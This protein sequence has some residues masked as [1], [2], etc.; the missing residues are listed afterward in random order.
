MQKPN[1]LIIGLAR[2]GTTS[3]Y[4]YL[5]QHPDIFLPSIKE[6]KFFSGRNIQYPHKGKGDDIVDNSRILNVQEYYSL[7]N[8]SNGEKAIGEASSDYFYHIRNC[9]KD[10]LTELG[11]ETK[12]ILCLRD[13]YERSF[14]AYNNLIRDSRETLSFSKGLLQEDYRKE[15]NY[16]WMWYYREGSIYHDKLK[17]ILENFHNVHL[18]FFED[19]KNNVDDTLKNICKFLCVDQNFSFD[20]ATKYSRSGKPK[21]KI[22]KI[23]TKR[24]G[25]IFKARKAIMQI[26]P[27]S[28][29]ER[30]ST[31]MFEKETINIECIEILKPTLNNDIDKLEE[32]LN[33]NLNHWKK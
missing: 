17:L 7:F 5:R 3:L 19:I 2:S 27:R 23:I 10:I 6:P 8:N 32:L 18:V 1:F 12:I 9:Y 33:I 30:L 15:N 16:D 26:L 22:F 4:H 29:L 31:S 28:I 13:P 24:Y 25:I 21:N 14:S 11:N 20:T